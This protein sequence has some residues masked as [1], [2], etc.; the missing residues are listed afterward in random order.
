MTKDTPA[1]DIYRYA[2]ITSPRGIQCHPADALTY[3]SHCRTSVTERWRDLVQGTLDEG[4]RATSRGFACLERLGEKIIID[5][6]APVVLSR[7]RKLGY[8]FMCAEAAW[9]LDGD[10]KVATIAP[11][12]RRIA[13]FSDDG[14]TFFGAYGPRLLPQLAYVLKTFAE[15]AGSRQAVATIWREN[16]PKTKDCPCS[17]SAQWLIR[18]GRLHCMLNMR[19]SDIWLGVPYDIFNF[20]MLSRY[21]LKKLPPGLALGDLHLYAGSSH[22]YEKDAAQAAEA[23]RS[24]E[25]IEAPINLAALDAAPPDKLASALWAMARQEGGKDV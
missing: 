1:A 20:S 18:E 13:S 14:V 8:H 10:N 3:P 5:M 21:L 23:A 17:L 15:D 2:S 12:S 11:F 25:V 19:S 9:L 7:E 22:L 24:N 6:Q 16:P 4:A